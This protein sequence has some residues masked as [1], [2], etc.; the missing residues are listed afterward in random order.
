MLGMGIPVSCRI[1]RKAI[2]RH[3]KRFNH[4][5][6]Y[7]VD[8]VIMNTAAAAITLLAYFSGAKLLDTFVFVLF[9]ESGLVFVFA[10][11]FGF[12]FTQSLLLAFRRIFRKI[13]TGE[14]E[15]KAQTKEKHAIG[16]RLILL[17]GILMTETLLL[18]LVPF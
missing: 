10:G 1:I 18:A 8:F 17:G 11:L 16:N 14:E 4:L 9:V 6:R 5:K 7:I 2:Y 12:V 15:W 3:I 13:E